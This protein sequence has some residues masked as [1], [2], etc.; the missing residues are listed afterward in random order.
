[1]PGRVS[2][3]RDSCGGREEQLGDEG[4]REGETWVASSGH[5]ICTLGALQPGARTAATSEKTAW[6]GGCVERGP[7]ACFPTTSALCPGSAAGPVPLAQPPRTATQPNA[8][9]RVAAHPDASVTCSRDLCLFPVG[10]PMPHALYKPQ[11]ASRSTHQCP[12]SSPPLSSPSIPPQPL[13]TSKHGTHTPSD[14]GVQ[15]I[16]TQFRSLARERRTHP[17]LRIPRVI[18]LH[19]LLS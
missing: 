5:S 7:L 17:H 12:S 4:R 15:L 8:S 18:N 1:M 6:T 14:V 16:L 13:S 19:I 11:P 9:R 10:V 2:G 3:L